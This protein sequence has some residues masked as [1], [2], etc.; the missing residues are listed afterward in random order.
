MDIQNRAI[1]G[2]SHSFKVTRD[3]SAVSLLESREQNAS[4][5]RLKTNE[6]RTKGHFY[7]GNFL[8]T[9]AEGALGDRT[10]KF[11]GKKEAYLT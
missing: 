9:I 1:E 6:Q 8:W 2:Y 5:H 11:S 10:T 3:K 4:H 7:K